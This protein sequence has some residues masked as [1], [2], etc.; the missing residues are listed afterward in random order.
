[1][2]VAPPHTHTI[3]CTTARNQRLPSCLYSVTDV[4]KQFYTRTC[5]NKTTGVFFGAGETSLLAAAMPAELLETAVHVRWESWVH[6]S[7]A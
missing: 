1:M 6:A 5:T 4:H 2:A 7:C 3:T